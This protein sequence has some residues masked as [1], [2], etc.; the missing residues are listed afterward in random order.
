MMQNENDDGRKRTE[1]MKEA[2]W[3]I[4]NTQKE[5]RNAKAKTKMNKR[6]AKRKTDK[7]K[8]W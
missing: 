7:T 2:K 1:F 5:K 3:A 8:F 6:K 4:V